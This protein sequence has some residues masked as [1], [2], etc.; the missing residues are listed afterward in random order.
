MQRCFISVGYALQVTKARLHAGVQVLQHNGADIQAVH[1]PTAVRRSTR[2]STQPAKHSGGSL[3]TVP[4]AEPGQMGPPDF[5]AKTAEHGAEAEGVA[6]AAEPANG[7]SNLP[8]PEWDVMEV[9]FLFSLTPL[10][11]RDHLAM[12]LLG[13]P[14]R[15]SHHVPGYCSSCHATT[16]ALPVILAANRPKGSLTY[17]SPLGF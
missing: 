15:S 2:T 10:L 6:L 9:I 5:A 4:Q 14:M 11:Q 13:F 3:D 7:K 17:K 8:E 1:S 12:S 16:H